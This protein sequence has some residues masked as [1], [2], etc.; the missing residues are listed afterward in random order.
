MSYEG[1]DLSLSEARS[2][3]FTPGDQP[4]RIVKAL[5]LKTDAVII[6]LEDSVSAQNKELAR[7]SIVKPID[8]H[9]VTGGPLVIIRINAFSSPEFALDLK[10]ALSLKVDAIMLPKFVPG[11]EAE[12][13]DKAIETMEQEFGRPN[14]L[15][16]IPLIESTAGVL[17]L[18]SVS[19]FPKRVIRLAF[20]AADLYADL[21]VTYSES[22]ANSIFAMA[23]IVMASV[24]CDLASPIDAP[25]FKIEDDLGLE[26]SSLFAKDMG[27]GA[28]LCIHPEQLAIVASSFKPNLNEKKWAS[29]VMEKWDQRSADK[30]AILVDGFLIDEAMIKRA[31]HILS[32]M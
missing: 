27:F 1:Q 22:G 4:E 25:H 24:N 32:I 6:D 14:L 15:P 8:E 17:K 2:F 11:S 21:G 29:R 20:G 30:G 7:K 19:S 5:Q 31:R 26:T 12:S 3:L 23:T 28:K 10:V 16:V 18:I 13:V 9:R